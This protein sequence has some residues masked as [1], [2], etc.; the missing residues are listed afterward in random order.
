MYVAISIWAQTPAGAI[1]ITTCMQAP[2]KTARCP[3]PPGAGN[4]SDTGNRACQNRPPPGNGCSE[5]TFCGQSRHGHRGPQHC[6]SLAVNVVI[7]YLK[8]S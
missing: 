4:F 6:K 1:Q 7:S 8:E 5:E 2:L 3:L